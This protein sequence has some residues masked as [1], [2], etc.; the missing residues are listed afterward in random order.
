MIQVLIQKSLIFE[1]LK[2]KKF[3][4]NKDLLLEISK[5]IEANMKKKLKFPLSKNL[6]I[7][8]DCQFLYLKNSWKKLNGGKGRSKFL[9]KLES[10]T[11]LLDLNEDD[12]LS[13][14][15]TINQR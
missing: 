6:Q 14:T 8:L 13:Q 7:K 5:I 4:R 3:S 1:I 11:L 12:I 15:S 2:E 10:E 9:K